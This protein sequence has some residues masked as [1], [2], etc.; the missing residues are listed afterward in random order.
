[1]EEKKND[2]EVNDN[3]EQISAEE[4]NEIMAKYD[5]ES[6]VRIF[7]GNKALIIKIMLIAFTVFAVAINTVIQFNAQVHRV[8]GHDCSQSNPQHLLLDSQ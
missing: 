5:R 4:V 7:A 2:L 3:L 6:A 1:M 8:L